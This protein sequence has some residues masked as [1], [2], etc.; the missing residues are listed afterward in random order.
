MERR[1]MNLLDDILSTFDFRLSPLRLVLQF[2]PLLVDC[3]FRVQNFR[4]LAHRK[5]LVHKV[6][7]TQRSELPLSNAI[8]ML[9]LLSLFI[10][11]SG[12][13]VGVN[14]TCVSRFP[15]VG[16]YNASGPPCC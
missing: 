4:F 6:V 12:G 2:A 15:L 8:F 10:A 13:Y 1:K 16:S 3:G 7:M 14:D 5:K 9:S 11:L